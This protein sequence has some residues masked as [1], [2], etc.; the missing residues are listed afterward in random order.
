MI[1]VLLFGALGKMGQEIAVLFKNTGDVD[2]TKMVDKCSFD[3][4]DF[5]SLTGISG[6]DLRVMDEAEEDL[7]SGIDCI[8]EFTRHDATVKHLKSA[9]RFGIPYVIGTTGFD[10]KELEIIHEASEKTAVFISSNMSLGINVIDSLLGKFVG[11]FP[12]YDVELWEL[13]HRNKKDSPS[14][15]AMTLAKTIKDSCIDDR[16]IVTG[17]TGVNSGRKSNEIS[18]SSIRGGDI[19]GEHHILFA[20]VGENIEIIH[21]ATSRE[22]FA[23]GTLKAVRFIVQKKKGIYDFKDLLA[24]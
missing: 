10:K 19:F 12:K 20:G 4:N 18:I 1:R 16:I 2:I 23:R 7:F 9:K 22:V 14:G 6:Y 11:N 5:R 24:E 13:H 3:N 17:R 8:V 15:T 21:R